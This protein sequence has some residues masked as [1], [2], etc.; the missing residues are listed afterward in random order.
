MPAQRFELQFGVYDEKKEP[1][2]NVKIE[3]VADKEDPNKQEPKVTVTDRNTG[4]VKDPIL[5]TLA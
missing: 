2:R 4:F 1:V 3:I 5:Q